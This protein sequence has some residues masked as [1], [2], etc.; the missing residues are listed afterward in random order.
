L[1]IPL[2]TSN[3]PLISINTK[4]NKQSIHNWLTVRVTLR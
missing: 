2:T 1:H 4:T 3:K